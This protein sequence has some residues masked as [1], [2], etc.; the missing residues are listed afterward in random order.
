MTAMLSDV[1]DNS[2]VIA[3]L[4]RHND[5]IEKEKSK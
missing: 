5:L 2:G 4:K 3:A 1:Q